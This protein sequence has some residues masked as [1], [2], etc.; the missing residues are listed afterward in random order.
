MT[1]RPAWLPG[2]DE[3]L[4]VTVAVLI[5]TGAGLATRPDRTIHRASAQEVMA[6]RAGASAGIRASSVGSTGTATSLL[7]PT[8]LRSGLPV[9]ARGSGGDPADE[10][11]RLATPAKLSVAV[12]GLFGAP[13][14]PVGTNE[15]GSMTV[16]PVAEVGWYQYAGRP[17]GVGSVVLAAHVAEGGRRGLFARLPELAA[18]D[19]VQVETTAGAI[20]EWEVESVT[21]Y[22]KAKLPVAELFRAEGEP[23]LILITC[24]GA[25]DP[26]RGSYGDN[27][28]VRARP[29]PA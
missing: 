28:V 5:G 15:D 23:M 24:G 6:A 4:A 2:R 21:S 9:G 29:V 8:P 26:T 1:A 10:S 16:P 3:V 17:D 22:A 20:T 7:P 27:V 14:R 11:A 19:R 25:I 12:L 13:V 18:G